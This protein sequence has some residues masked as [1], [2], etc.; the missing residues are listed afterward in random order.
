MKKK[1]SQLNKDL[2]LRRYGKNEFTKAVD[3][4]V[5][6]ENMT[7][8]Q[9][10][11][12]ICTAY[13]LTPPDEVAMVRGS[14]KKNT[15]NNAITTETVL[16]TN[17]SVKILHDMEGGW[18]PSILPLYDSSDV[19]GGMPTREQEEI[20]VLCMADNA[21]GNTYNGGILSFEFSTTYHATEHWETIEGIQYIWY[22]KSE[23]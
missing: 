3:G 23:D 21:L 13:D 15:K 5:N 22:E 4:G 18:Y 9:L 7:M 6:P 11:Q 14:G 1:L 12:A 17:E 8:I 10:M 2:D 20:N 19:K 16:V